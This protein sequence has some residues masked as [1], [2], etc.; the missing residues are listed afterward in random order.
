[1]IIFDY[2]S[3]DSELK[4]L[5]NDL[6]VQGLR[7]VVAKTILD[8]KNLQNQEI[9]AGTLPDVDNSENADPNAWLDDMK[10]DGTWVDNLFIQLFSNWIRRD[11]MILPLYPDDGH[12]DGWIKI[13]AKIS[14]GKV[15]MLYYPNKH[16]Q[17]IM[18]KIKEPVCEDNSTKSGSLEKPNDDIIQKSPKKKQKNE[19][20]HLEDSKSFSPYNLRTRP[21][22]K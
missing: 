2:F 18:P 20:K 6:G 17:S 9:Q 4:R 15:Y 22:K 14:H 8:D 19:D 7:E 21:S 16:Y 1:M 13:P 3:L 12:D 11:I 5:A 10:K